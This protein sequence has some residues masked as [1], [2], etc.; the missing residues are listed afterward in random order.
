MSYTHLILEEP[1]LSKYL[2]AR[3]K[4]AGESPSI[5]AGTIQPFPGKY[6]ATAQKKAIV[7]K[8]LINAPKRDERG[9]VTTVL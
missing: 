7:L 9:R 5:L 8:P 3:V 4:P 2:C 1:P 6:A